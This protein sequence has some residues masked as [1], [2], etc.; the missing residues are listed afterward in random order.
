MKKQLL[1]LSLTIAFITGKAQIT[2]ESSVYCISGAASRLSIVKFNSLGEKYVLVDLLADTISV[3][4]LNHVLEKSFAIP[5]SLTITT[6]FVSYVSDNLFDM[7][8]SIEYLV[9]DQIAY[10]ITANTYVVKEDG[11]IIFSDDSAA[12]ADL[13]NPNQIS[14]F[15]G[16][17]PSSSGTKM[18]LRKI[19]Y[20]Y[21]VYA[22]PGLLPCYEC[23]GGNITGNFSPANPHENFSTL[24]N[25]YP[26]PA[27]NLTR[28]DYHL[29]DGVKQGELVFFNT[30]GVEIK[31]FKV[32]NAF[33]F[34]YVSTH[35]LPSGTY[36]YTLETV[37]GKSDG[38]K[39][40]VVR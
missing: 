11:S 29:V 24:S 16:I 22:L 3:F 10:G 15:A 36:Y 39:M 19:N 9:S 7:D 2:F 31:R 21:S 38:K 27:N 18:V 4:S 32:T 6:Y 30:V 40:V 34:I 33:N 5:A 17:Y 8:S 28:I 13:Q 37:A 20:G 26:N 1:I 23:S 25:P 35:D 14:E 12:I